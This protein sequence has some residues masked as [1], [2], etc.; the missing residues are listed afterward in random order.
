LVPLVDSE[1]DQ[2]SDPPAVDPSTV[3]ANAMQLSVFTD[4]QL[5]VTDS[6]GDTVTELEPAVD[7]KPLPTAVGVALKLID[8]NP[9]NATVIFTSCNTLL[10]AGP[11]HVIEYF[12]SAFKSENIMLPEV[13]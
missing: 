5:K 8:G 11:L 9:A 13:A 3:A 12:V 10:P 6:L 7:A 1:P 2:L 4:D